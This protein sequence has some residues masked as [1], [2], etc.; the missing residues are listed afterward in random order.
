MQIFNK[1]NYYQQAP[2]PIM[3]KILLLLSYTQFTNVSVLPL[4]DKHWVF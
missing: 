3:L 4:C 2:V 1:K